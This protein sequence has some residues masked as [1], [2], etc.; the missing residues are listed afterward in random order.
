MGR[1][2]KDK[3][4]KIKSSY[5]VDV[6]YSFS[7]YN[8]Y[9]GDPYG[10]YLNYIKHAPKNEKSSIY[11]VQG[12]GIHEI[13]QDY[14]ENKTK[15]EDMIDKYEDLLFG[16]NN[17]GYKYSKSDKDMNENIA[18]KYEN[19]VRHFFMNYKPLGYKWLVEKPITIN[20]NG[21]VFI[22][23]IDLITKVGDTY[24]IEDI[25]S[26]TIYTGD[27]RKKESAQLLLYAIG[28]GQKF[29]IGLDKIKC[30][31]NFIKYTT[32]EVDLKTIDKK[33]GKH[34]TKTKDCVRCQWVKD[35]S[36]DLRK[37]LKI[38]EYDELEIEDII[39]TCI[40]K[41]NLDD[42]PDIAS[43]FRL[44][45]CYVY[46]DLTQDNVDE[47]C[48]KINKTIKEIEEKT[49]TTMQYLDVI[50]NSIDDNKKE[51]YDKLID[52]LWW[53]DITKADLYYFINLCDYDRRY[54]K[55][56]DEYLKNSEMFFKSDNGNNKDTEED[57]SFDW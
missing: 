42:Y 31:W 13:L 1:L 2:S 14:L 7:R 29:N 35:I 19:S 54:H 40:K 23:Y 8:S 44:D 16:L 50:D 3:L 22:G 21:D 49:Y 37:W 55:P 20:I 33:T 32:V 34:K 28:V 24:I 30:R 43:H 27:K 4:E 36:G 15:Y 17:D 47:L 53:Q 39:Q 10:Y 51:Y 11:S 46:I 9:L 38:L 6:L 18:N 52:E 41:N 5:G 57:N 12:S 25:K 45:D 48:N 56:Y 26:S